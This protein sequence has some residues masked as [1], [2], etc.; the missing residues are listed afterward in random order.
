MYEEVEY[1][2]TWYITH[3]DEELEISAD[4]NGKSV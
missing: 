3:Q 2:W 1:A 4:L